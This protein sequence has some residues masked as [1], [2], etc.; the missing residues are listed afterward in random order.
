MKNKVMILDT[1]DSY[2]ILY[3]GPGYTDI[4][5]LYTK[6]DIDIEEIETN[7]CIESSANMN[8]IHTIIGRMVSYDQKCNENID[9]LDTLKQDIEKINSLYSVKKFWEEK[10]GSSCKYNDDKYM[11]D[12]NDVFSKNKSLFANELL[13]AVRSNIY[14]NDFKNTYILFHTMYNMSIIVNS[15]DI[16]SDICDITMLLPEFIVVVDSTLLHTL[17]DST[18]KPLEYLFHKKTFDRIEEVK[19]RY[20]TF[21]KLYGIRN[22]AN[23][24][25][26]MSEDN[27]TKEKEKV[28]RY[29]DW[30]YNISGDIDKRMKANDLYD[31]LLNHMCISEKHRALCKRRIAAYLIELKLQKKRYSDGYYYFGIE[32]KGKS[33]ISLDDIVKNRSKDLQNWSCKSRTNNDDVLIEMAKRLDENTK[34]LNHDIETANSRNIIT[35]FTFKTNLTS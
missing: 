6:M 7:I 9:I 4:I 2:I 12:K 19:E 21:E 17:P 25:K 20:T 34:Q 16:S 28:K 14:G 8:F 1:G 27:T 5:K 22:D 35:D 10:N 15:D 3:D 33:N 11:N 32:K 29:L 23:T 13:K 30:H 31:E 18:Y 24:T 26:N